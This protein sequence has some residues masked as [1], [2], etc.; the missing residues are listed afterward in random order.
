MALA[1]IVSFEGVSTA[2][3]EELTRE[4]DQQERPADIPATE[5]IVLH[6]AATE[7]SVVVLFFANE[8]DYEAADR[9]LDAMPPDETPGRRSSVAR[10]DVALRKTVGS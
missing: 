2:R 3:V 8:D 4:L 10:Y 1:R 9:T 5:I 6:D 7:R